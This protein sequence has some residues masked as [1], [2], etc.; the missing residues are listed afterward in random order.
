MA[1]GSEEI[2]RILQETSTSMGKPVEAVAGLSEIAETRATAGKRDR[3]L[4]RK[5]T[6]GGAVGGVIEEAGKVVDPFLPYPVVGMVGKTMSGVSDVAHGDIAQGG[7]KLASSGID[8]KKM[9]AKRDSEKKQ[10]QQAE[11]MAAIIQKLG[12]GTP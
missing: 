5:N 9:M 1:L 3:E 10:D 8:A 11:L 4:A 6:V 2:L 12:K 7:Q